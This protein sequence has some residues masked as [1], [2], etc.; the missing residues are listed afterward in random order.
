MPTYTFHGNQQCNGD[1]CPLCKASQFAD[2][3]GRSPLDP[4][5]GGYYRKVYGSNLFYAWADEVDN[6]YDPYA[7]HCDADEYECECEENTIEGEVISR[8]EP[9]PVPS[10]RTVE[11][12]IV[13]SADLEKFRTAIEKMNEAA[14]LR[15]EMYTLGNL[16]K[17]S[18]LEG[19]TEPS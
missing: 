18:V 9:R 13:L 5:I 1:R 17:N 19:L 15:L 8:S 4:P 2:H 7:C 14:A 10:A 16:L 12:S 6:E 11:M 3:Y